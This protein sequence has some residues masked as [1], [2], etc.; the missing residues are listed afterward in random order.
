MKSRL[1]CL[2]L[3]LIS[4]CGILAVYTATATFENHLSFVRNQLLAFAIGFFAVFILKGVSPLI[5]ERAAWAIFASCISLL[6]LVLV[7]GTGLEETGSKSWIYIGPVS[8]QPSEFVKIGFIVSFAAHISNTFDSVNSFK[9][10]FLLLL[11]ISAI[12]VPV[13]LQ[14]DFGTAFVF[15]FIAAIMLFAAGLS[16]KFYAAGGIGISVCLPAIWFFLKEYQKNRILVFF[17][18]ELDPTGTGYNVLQ[19]KTALGSGGL[20]GQ[21]YLNGM[22]TQSDLLPAKHT[23]FI[24]SVIGEETG[25][26]GCLAVELLLLF[27]ILCYIKTARKNNS[28]F[29]SSVATGIFAMMLCHCIINTGMCVGLVP[30]TGIPLP[31]VSYGGTFVISNLIAAGIIISIRSHMPVSSRNKSTHRNKNHTGR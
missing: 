27:I 16:W 1:L 20:T 9:S 22:L 10:I 21:G 30:V 23:D 18:P 3:I 15:L 26:A 19:S 11:H 7:M 17:N 5:L 4:V 31:F 25:F 8:F 2:L 14:P 6:I 29:E 24:F 12:V 13:I 28:V